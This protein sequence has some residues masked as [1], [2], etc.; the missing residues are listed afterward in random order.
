[1]GGRRKREWS[2]NGVQ[3]LVCWKTGGREPEAQENEWKSGT[4]GG[5]ELWEISRKYQRSRMR[6][7]SKNQFR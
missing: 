1:L 7:V 6:K 4:A 5:M 2:R 3:K